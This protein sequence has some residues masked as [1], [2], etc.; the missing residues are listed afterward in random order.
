V[1]DHPDTYYM[2]KALELAEAGLGRVAPNPSVSCLIVKDGEIIGRGGRTADGGRPHAEK[3]ALEEAGERARG[4]TAYVTLEP[5]W[6]ADRPS[7]STALIEAGVKR[8]VIACH[9][10]NP[11]IHGKGFTALK[12]AGIEVVGSCLE[13]RALKLNKG[14]FLTKL[15]QRPLVTLKMAVSLDS[16]IAGAGGHSQWITGEAAR[17]QVHIDRSRHDAILT[18]IGTILAD[19]PLLTT[20]LKN[21]DHKSRRIILDTTFR[22]NEKL[23]IN[24]TL[25]QGRI[26]IFTSPEHSKQTIGG[27]EILPADLEDNGKI[28]IP[29]VLKSLAVDGVTRLMVEAGQDVF[30]S[31]LKS[32][33]W[34]YLHLYRAPMIIGADGKD[35]FGALGV[36][37]LGKAPRL[38]LVDQQSLGDDVLEIYENPV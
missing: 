1:P 15:K 18:G 38:K 8:V 35:A 22:F 25:D 33:L 19:D 27:V 32:G 24:K 31:F 11:L 13:D 26:I 6:H 2:E 17:R 36:T 37:D 9:D 7:C 23:K 14:F 16:K 30:T 20:R 5:C 3:L 28:S 29:F 21:T 10:H 4:A 34:D 12:N